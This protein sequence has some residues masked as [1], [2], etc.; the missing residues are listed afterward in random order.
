MKG[1]DAKGPGRFFWLLALLPLIGCSDGG[2]GNVARLI[3]ETDGQ[4]PLSFDEIEVSITASR[5]PEG[6]LCEP[7]IEKFTIEDEG[8]LPLIVDYVFGSEYRSWAAFKV[9][10][11]MAGSV[12]LRKEVTS[13]FFSGE[14]NEIT[15]VIEEACFNASCGAGQQCLD[16][17]CV[18]L[19][20]PG[21]F[22][23]P[24]LIDFGTTC[25][26]SG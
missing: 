20:D 10:C 14:R 12:V 18:D 8:D 26:S 23:D 13:A 9:V 24:L 17:F 5:T 11:Y 15:L 1:R 7:A 16:G 25:D 4:A 2:G 19:P 22:S 3:I 6:N 21:P